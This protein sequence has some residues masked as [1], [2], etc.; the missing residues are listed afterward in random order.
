MNIYATLPFMLGYKHNSGLYFGAGA[1][2]GF[3]LYNIISGDFA[4]TDVNF[5]LEGHLS[6]V[7]IFKDVSLTNKSTDNNFMYLPQVNP[8]LE[9][10]WQ[11]L[12]V[13]NGQLL[14]Q[15]Q[16]TKIVQ[17]KLLLPALNI[18]LFSFFFTDAKILKKNGE[19][20]KVPLKKC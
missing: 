14:L 9:I 5:H 19:L 13:Q 16:G 11:G 7:G 18:I 20:Q 2:L 12:D 8:M 17:A 6:I 15:S 4:F 1:R 3:N 10:G